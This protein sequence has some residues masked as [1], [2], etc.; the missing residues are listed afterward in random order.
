MP[1]ALLLQKAALKLANCQLNAAVTRL[2]LPAKKSKRGL[3][4]QTLRAAY[5]SQSSHA[6]IWENVVGHLLTKVVLL[7]IANNDT[8]QGPQLY[9]LARLCVRVTSLAAELSVKLA[10]GQAPWK[11]PVADQEEPA[12]AADRV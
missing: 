7:D 12:E 6:H 2:G 10:L 4:S 11:L 8:M 9:P 5:R 3:V 1:A